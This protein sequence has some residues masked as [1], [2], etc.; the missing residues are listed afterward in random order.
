M[1]KAEKK[2][3]VNTCS[4]GKEKKHEENQIKSRSKW[5]II[6]KQIQ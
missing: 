1:R 5:I 4:E 3:K 2:D 6:T